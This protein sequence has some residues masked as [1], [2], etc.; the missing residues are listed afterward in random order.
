MENKA[1]EPLVT[2]HMSAYNHEKYIGDAI[3]SV[4]D[5]DYEN[6]EFI[7]IND[8]SKDNTHDVILTYIDACKSRFVRFEYINRYNKGLSATKM[9]CLAWAKGEYFTGIASDDV[10]L[11]N[12]VSLLVD[13]LENL[14]NSYAVAF[15]NAIFIDD[16]S[17]EVYIDK[18]TGMPTNKEKGFNLFLDYY[19]NGR[20]IDY[21]NA[22]IF[23]SYETLLSGNYLPAM[24]QVI[25]IK[26]LQEVGGWT[27]GNT[28][29]DWEMWLKL[30]K[31]YKFA[32]V[33]EP[34]A[35]YRWHDSNSCKLIG[36]NIHYDSIILLKND[37]E[38]AIE[39]NLK[40]MHYKYLVDRII[41]IIHYSKRDFVF[42]VLNNFNDIY[43]MKLF[44]KLFI[45]KLIKKTIK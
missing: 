36:K 1:T 9:E 32:Y 25:R 42:E 10:M 31:K 39:N 22:E 27:S 15:G 38:Y 29:E 14:D 3:Q 33:N 7:I 6:I 5:Q 11:S 45:K 41:G 43:F 28:I 19:T 44:I 23:G 37:K 40:D 8:G 35:L 20:N 16:K 4:I 24:S 34:V 18:K 17:N 13:K 26:M 12:K 30:S 2:A 21:K